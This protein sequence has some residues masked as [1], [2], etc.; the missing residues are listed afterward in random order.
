VLHTCAVLA[1]GAVKCW[2]GNDE[3]E[4]GTGTMTAS[5]VPLSVVQPTR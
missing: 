3:G 5:S 2:G 4:L 1:D